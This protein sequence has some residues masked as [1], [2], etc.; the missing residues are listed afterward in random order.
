VVLS[1]FVNTTG[2]PVFDG[3]LKQ[4]LAVADLCVE[5]FAFVFC[6]QLPTFWPP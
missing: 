1:E 6:F 3:A 2:D 4:A 5:S